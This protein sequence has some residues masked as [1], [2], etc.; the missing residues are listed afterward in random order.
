MND[1]QSDPL[2]TKVDDIDISYPIIPAGI[3]EFKITKAEV[4]D[5]SDRTGQNLVLTLQAT[6]P[7][8]SVKGETVQNFTTTNNI[9][10][11]ETEKYMKVEIG[12]RIATV[13]KAAE[14]TGVSPKDIIAK[15]EILVGRV[16]QA[17]T[18]VSQERT[19]PKTGRIYEPRSEVASFVVK[20]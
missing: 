8:Q 13:A 5:N 1:Q 17:K 14:I 20:K 2:D 10:L 15:P 9:S 11:T 18:Q 12:K 19:D 7:I 6:R 16:V 4:K 3:H